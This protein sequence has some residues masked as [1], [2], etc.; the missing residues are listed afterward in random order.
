MENHKP[1]DS[2]SGV[3]TVEKLSYEE[4]LQEL[5][6]IVQKLEAE[7]MTLE[8]SINLYDR[9]QQ[10]VYHCSSLLERAELRVQ[11]IEN[12]KLVPFEME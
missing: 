5:E 7:Q 8:E 11:Q 3:D 4:A 9:G 10:L 1:T 6:K 2:D 12:Q